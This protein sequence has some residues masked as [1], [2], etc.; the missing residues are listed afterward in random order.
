LLMVC[1]VPGISRE[2]LHSAAEVA[3]DYV[4]RFCGGEAGLAEW[5]R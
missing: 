3:V 4:K 5:F 2:V 1:G